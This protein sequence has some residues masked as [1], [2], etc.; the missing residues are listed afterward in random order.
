VTG[1][2]IERGQA[3]NID[4]IRV[5]GSLDAET[6]PRLNTLLESLQAEGRRR[7]VLDCDK[8]QYISSVNLG[9]LL[10]FCQTAQKDGGGLRLARVSRKIQDVVKVLGFHKILGIYPGVEKAVRG[11]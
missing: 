4:I 7:V 6:F 5:D 8:L 1:C 10:G 2:T 11:F 3:G 9:A